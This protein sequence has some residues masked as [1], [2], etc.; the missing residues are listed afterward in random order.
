M[1]KDST[2]R[3]SV[4]TYVCNGV[5]PYGRRYFTSP[6]KSEVNGLTE[7]TIPSETELKDKV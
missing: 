5:E 6:G 4:S 7:R 1:V 2:T 3:M